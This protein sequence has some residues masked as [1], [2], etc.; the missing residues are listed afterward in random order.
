MFKANQLSVCFPPSFIISAGNFSDGI[1]VI[2]NKLD[3]FSQLF[4]LTNISNQMVD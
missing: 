3:A 2:M 4:F 1:Y